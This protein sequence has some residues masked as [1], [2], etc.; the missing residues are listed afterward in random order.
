MKSRIMNKSLLTG[1]IMMFLMLFTVTGYSQACPGNKVTV[2]LQNITSPTTTTLEFDVYVSNSGSTSLQFAALQGAVIY[3]AGLLPTGATGTFTCITQPSQTGNFPNFNPLASVTHTAATRQLKWTSTPVTASSGNTVTLPANTPMKFARF[4]LTSD[5][6]WA[7]NFPAALALRNTTGSGYTVVAATVYCNGNGSSTALLSSSGTLVCNDANNTPYGISLNTQVCATLAS[8]TAS[9]AVTCFGSSNGSSTI[10]MTPTPT[11]SDITYTVDGGTSQSATVSNGV[12]TI[13]GLTAGTHTVVIS[14]TGCADVTATGVSVDGPASLLASSSPGTIACN[15]GTTSVVV[16]ATGGTT[17]YLG[18]GAFTA[19]AG[20]YSYTVTDANGCTSV[21]LGTIAEPSILAASSS[22]GTISCHG[23][24]TTVVVSATGGTAPYTGTGSFTVSAGDYSYTVTDA[25]GCSKT[26]TGT[27]TEPSAIV[28][29]SSAGTISCHGGATTVVVSATGGTGSY[30]GTGSFTHSAGA[31]SY[32]VTDANGCTSVASGTIAEPSA[33]LASGSASAILCN[34]G[35]STVT[36]SAAGGT[37]PYVGTGDF[38]VSAGDYSYTVTDANGCTN[39]TTVNVS[40]PTVLVAS[41]SATAILCTGSNSTI[42]VSATGGTA[43][44]TGTGAFTRAAGAYSYTV[45]DANGCSKTTTGT[46]TVTPAYTLTLTSAANTN[47]QAKCI[48]TAI[49]SITYAATGTLTGVAATGLPTGVTAA[50]VAATKILTISGTP[51]VAGNFTYTVTATGT[52]GTLTTTGTISVSPKAVVGTI[53]GAGAICNG[54]SKVLTLATGSIGTIQWQSNVSSSAT[55]PAATDAN[56]ANIDGATD[57][58]TYTASPS[59]TTW[60]RAV[61]T[62]GACSFIASAAVAVT[63]SQPTA[64]GELSALAST[65]CTGSGTTLNLENATG[66]ISWQKATVTNGVT[67]AFTA[68]A[69]NTTTTLATGN[70]TATTAYKVVVSS[71]VCSTST[72]N[73]VTVTVSPKSTVKTITGAGAICNGSSKV[74]TLATGSIGTIQWQS[75]VSSS[76]TAPAATDAN[77]ANIDGATDPVTY[78][79]SPSTT[80]WYR[81]VATSGACSFIASAAVAVTVSQPTAVGELSALAST[82]CTGS[83]T[84]LNLE[85]ATGTISWQKATVTN[86]V[87]GAFTAVAGNTTTTL[88]T[89]NLTATTAYKVVVSSGACST[90]TSNVVTVTVSPKSLVK[91]ISGAG[92]ICNGGNK[93]LTLAT[94]SIGSIQWQSNVSSSTTAPAATDANWANIDGATDPVTYTASPSTTTWYRAVA[95]SGAC[96]FIASAAVAVTVSQPTAVGELSA[97]ASTVCTASGTTLNLT[98]ATGTIAW[99]KATVV[100]GVT[101]TF[102]AVAGNTTTT[103]AT[104]NLTATTAYKVVVSSGVCSTSTSNIV[105]VTVSPAAKATAVS[106]NAGATT[107][108]TAVCSGIKTLTLAT[109]YVGVIQWQYY[110][111]GS[112]AT[113]VTNTTVAATWTDID[114]AT[115]TTLSAVSSAAGNVWF[116]VKFTSGPCATLAYSTPVNVWIKACGSSVRIE[117]AIEFKAI[118]YPNPFAENFKLD[119][120]TSSEEALQIKVYDMLGK[121]VENRILEVSEIEGLEVGANYPSG[122]YNVIVSQGDVVKTLRVIKR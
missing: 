37:A 110:N 17:P 23:G 5:M 13:T 47:A 9:S 15:G 85:N 4:R 108:A 3:N 69:G 22:A 105:I 21:T 11:V 97:L 1:L 99:Q 67:G 96:S 118:A 8:Q 91:T 49:T 35:N 84:T 81:A 44:Y 30:T 65:V 107:L 74:L 48:S 77:W 51:S 36:V 29:S 70:L 27:I 63:V 54:S 103:L 104:G 80:T 52:C 32:T 93:V 87:T 6:V 28:S 92:A 56:W 73:V 58:V 60:Y 88:A 89:G 112:S 41:S 57:P 76:A 75:N 34:G 95:T 25:N 115:G 106:G 53:S 31:Y 40:Q 109:G 38:T 71:G 26:T 55:A 62:S 14:N 117:D 12:F 82:V 10:T 50:Y 7:Q 119:V 2:T 46:I 90:S 68:V 64:V 121:L 59:T 83:G 113:A 18:T 98:N 86:G 66:T 20:A 43:P 102:A 45:T 16:S 42:T 94:G 39:T 33:L 100:N 61:A 79:A 72:S 114:G 120:K 78:T 101:G 122:V 24:T 116:R 111:A 19:S